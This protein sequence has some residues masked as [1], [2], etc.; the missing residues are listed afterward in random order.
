MTS[1]SK[2]RDAA[3]VPTSLT[4]ILIVLV[5]TGILLFSVGRI[6]SNALEDDPGWRAVFDGFS[7]LSIA[8]VT[9]SAVL[10]IL[11]LTMIDRMVNRIRDDVGAVVAE[12]HGKL[13]NTV[14]HRLREDSQRIHQMLSQR[15]GAIQIREMGIVDHFAQR[16]DAVPQILD[17]IAAARRVRM[18]GVCHSLFWEASEYDDA[19]DDES[20]NE[21]LES[22]LFN[23]LKKRDD[24]QVEIVYLARDSQDQ[25]RARQLAE[26]G[27]GDGASLLLDTRYSLNHYALPM[28]FRF[29][30]DSWEAIERSNALE[31]YE[32][33]EQRL[34]QFK[35]YES[36]LSPTMSLVITDSR[37]FAS[38]YLADSNC[39][40]E[41]CTVYEKRTD[42]SPVADDWD[43][44]WRH[45]EKTRD[46][47]ER[48]I[49]DELIQLMARN[50]SAVRELYNAR[51]GD[52]LPDRRSLRSDRKGSAE[53]FIEELGM[54]LTRLG[55]KNDMDHTG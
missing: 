55:P 14:D 5:F 46:E 27:A 12:H 6:L 38:P 50:M 42:N 9:A 32:L 28:F 1:E 7:D 11:E 40:D 21:P 15:L 23:L 24:S 8:V 33:M 19:S 45:Y 17:S 20:D 44:C 4:I 41:P 2:T 22:R 35:L 49:T 48:L 30:F 51:V 39:F 31:P 36:P 18:L 37:M 34:R 53:K 16:K 54:E 26:T 52:D 43:A 10:L 25:Y 13:H 47:S 3:I 29:A